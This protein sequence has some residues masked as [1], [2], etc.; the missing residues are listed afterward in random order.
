MVGVK[1]DKKTVDMGDHAAHG[2]DGTHL[3]TLEVAP[4]EADHGYLPFEL[5]RNKSDRQEQ[6]AIG[7]ADLVRSSSARIG[8]GVEDAF[9]DL[10]VRVTVGQ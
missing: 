6:W 5:L 9:K 2:A 1:I 8:K 4:I 7:T 10:T 3:S